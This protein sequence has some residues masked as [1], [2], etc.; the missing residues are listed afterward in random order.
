MENKTN[1]KVNYLVVDAWW[2]GVRS[3][4][5][6]QR[7]QI[8]YQIQYMPRHK[9]EIRNGTNTRWGSWKMTLLWEPIH[10]LVVVAHL[11]GRFLQSMQVLN[12]KYEKA[13][14]RNTQWHKYKMR[15]MENETSVGAHPWV[16]R[17][18]LTWMVAP[19]AF[20]ASIHRLLPPAS[21]TSHSL[22]ASASAGCQFSQTG[23]KFQISI[24]GNTIHSPP[25]T[26]PFG[27]F[28]LNELVPLGV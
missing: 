20:L 25:P 19:L 17:W 4:W 28:F 18:S 3:Q 12:T 10:E 26:V 1:D 2:S 9:Y 16:G 22:E 15:V 24:C 7:H 27:H 8:Q 23:K 21:S 5:S 13:Q 11:D 6:M 14:T